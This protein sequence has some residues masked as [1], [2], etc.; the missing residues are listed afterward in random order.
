MESGTP[1]AILVLARRYGLVGLWDAVDDETVLNPKAK[2][3][4]QARIACATLVAAESTMEFDT[5][6][7]E[8]VPPSPDNVQ[9]KLLRG[10]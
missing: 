4:R 9:R 5:C 1:F 6:V 10:A 8:F 2:W 3:L 7:Q